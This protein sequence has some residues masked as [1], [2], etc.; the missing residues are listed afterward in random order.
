MNNLF[1][2]LICKQLNQ[3]KK[4]LFMIYLSRLTIYINQFKDLSLL[5]NIKFLDHN[6]KK[7]IFCKKNDFINL[8]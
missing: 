2:F 1:Q 7:L 6:R 8:I 4:I 5:Y 3:S